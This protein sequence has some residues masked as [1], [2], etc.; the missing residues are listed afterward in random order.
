[1]FLMRRLAD[2]VDEGVVVVM[3]RVRGPPGRTVG[4]AGGGPS[5]GPPP[6]PSRRARR[7]SLFSSKRL[8]RSAAEV[9]STP[10][11]SMQRAGVTLTA[12]APS[13]TPGA[14]RSRTTPHA[15]R[16]T[17]TSTH[18]ALSRPLMTP[19]HVH[20]WYLNTQ[21]G[22]CWVDIR[23]P[24]NR[25]SLYKGLLDCTREYLPDTELTHPTG[26]CHVGSA[27]M[28]L[29]SLKHTRSRRGAS[30]LA[31]FT[32]GAHAIPWQDT[33]SPARAARSLVAPHS[34]TCIRSGCWHAA[35]PPARPHTT[36]DMGRTHV[37][38]HSHTHSL[39]R[40]RAAARLTRHA[41]S[42]NLATTL[43]VSC[44]GSWM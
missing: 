40:H 13:H 14:L 28:L 39:M 19:A 22:P 10:A 36:T 30:W 42:H 37:A 3:A 4:G 9:R 35:T 17:H 41:A 23:T 32:L 12:L 5:D 16:R 15:H 18:D 33:P 31:A 6:T 24:P 43:P 29:F 21:Y 44:R 2:V 34:L 26:R 25:V 27:P 20:S 8:L 1:V 38:P 11:Q 7:I